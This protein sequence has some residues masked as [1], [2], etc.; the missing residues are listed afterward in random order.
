[1][2]IEEVST[3]AVAYQGR[4]S[5]PES[6][7]V[8]AEAPEGG[9]AAVESEKGAQSKPAANEDGANIRT[10]DPNASAAVSTESLKKAVEELNKNAKNSEAIFGIHDATNRLTIKIVDKDT[11]KVIKEYPPE[12]S[13]DMIAK[14]WEMAGL[15]VDEKG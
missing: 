9:A 10:E 2:T 3:K 14:V 1:M 11:K 5:G 4:S 13:L 8:S 15:M 7:Q 6:A 12:K